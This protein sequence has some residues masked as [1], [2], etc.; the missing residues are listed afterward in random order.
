MPP[1]QPAYEADDPEEDTI[2]LT[3]RM[4]ALNGTSLN[5]LIDIYI[6]ACRSRLDHQITVDGYEYQLI[7]FKDWWQVQG[8]GQNWRL[9]PSDFMRFEKFLRSAISSATHRVISYHTRHTIIKRLKEMFGWAF[10]KHYLK[11]DYGSWIPPADGGPPK[12]SAAGLPSL[13]KLLRAAGEGREAVRN[14]AVV[15]MLMGMGLRRAELSGIDIE[16]VVVHADYSGNSE[17]VGKRTRANKTGERKVAFDIPTGKIIVAY[18]DSQERISGPLFL[19][20]R[21]ER[22]TGQGIYKVVKD[23]IALASL[24]KQITGP[25]DLRRAFSTHWARASPGPDS[26]HRRQKQL[27]HESYEQTM[28]YTLLDVDDIRADLISPLAL[29]P[30]DDPY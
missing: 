13:Q 24:E 7:W 12:R 5:L 1:K 3:P 10:D 8:P 23:A 16:K 6:D 18:L 15:A 22:L 26:A 17:V 29:F 21:G 20:Q 28:E 19:G 2:D 14:R 27:G 25:H 4:P 9:L 30:D 11:R